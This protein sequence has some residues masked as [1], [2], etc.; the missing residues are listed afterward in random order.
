MMPHDCEEFAS[1]VSRHGM[2]SNDIRDIVDAARQSE[3]NPLYAE[4]IQ[5]ETE[6]ETEEVEF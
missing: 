5:D 1:I 2:W 4:Q 6:N 3:K